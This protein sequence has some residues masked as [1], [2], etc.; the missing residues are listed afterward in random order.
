M[1][2]EDTNTNGYVDGE[3]RSLLPDQLGPWTQEQSIRYEV[4]EDLLGSL[5]AGCAGRLYRA[6]RAD[7]PDTEA[8]DRWRS[9]KAEWCR[10]RHELTW[11]TTE[12]I[13][14][15]IKAYAPLARTRHEE[16]RRRLQLDGSVDE[17]PRP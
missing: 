4:A 16:T 11:A 14:E 3:Y 6:Q 10:R 8:A 17:S 12:Q 5:V 2:A 15:T 7:P 1:A 13:E 9:E